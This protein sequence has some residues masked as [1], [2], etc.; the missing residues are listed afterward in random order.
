MGT[1]IFGIRH[2]GPGCA[3]ALRSAIE[4]LASKLTVVP[5]AGVCVK[6]AVAVF[7]IT[8]LLRSVRLAAC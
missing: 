3:R 8:V 6:L 1:T 5:A 7:P 2:H 4:A